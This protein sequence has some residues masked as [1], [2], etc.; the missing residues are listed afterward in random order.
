[1]G[2][3][4]HTRIINRDLSPR[5]MDTRGQSGA[6]E[7]QAGNEDQPQLAIAAKIAE[8]RQIVQ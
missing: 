3:H 5:R 8:L 7:A 4:T 2:S 6:T 1:M